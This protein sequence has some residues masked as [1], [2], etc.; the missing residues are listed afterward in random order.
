MKLLKGL[1]GNKSL[2]SGLGAQLLGGLMGGGGGSQQSSQSN[3]MASILSGVLG[4]GGNQASGSNNLMSGLL[5]SL[6]GGDSGGAAPSAAQQPQTGSL[7]SAGA[8]MVSGMAGQA[9]AP[10]ADANEQAILMIRAMVN[11][12]K[13]DGRIDQAEQENIVSK[14]GDDVSQAEIDFLR[15]E[16]AAPIDVAG[17]ARSIPRGMEQQIYAMSLTSIELDTQNEANYL[18]QLA[19]GLDIDSNLCNQIHDHLGAPK[20]FG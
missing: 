18:G 1:M 2:S 15:K 10:Q 3:P 8:G 20:I 17:F 14:L 12:A 5:G 16:F 11:A 19:Q 7:A 6:M 13:S 4:G 9:A